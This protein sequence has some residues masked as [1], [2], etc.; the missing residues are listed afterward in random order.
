M[1]LYIQV[2][3]DVHMMITC[4]EANADMYAHIEVVADEEVLTIDM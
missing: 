1:C 2:V 3:V 4:V